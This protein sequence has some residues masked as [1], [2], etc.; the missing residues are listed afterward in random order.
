MDNGI[1][2]MVPPFIEAGEKIVVETNEI[3]Y[4]KRAES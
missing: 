4:V 1:K 3:T 2:V